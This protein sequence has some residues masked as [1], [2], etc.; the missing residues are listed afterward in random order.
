MKAIHG[1]L[2]NFGIDFLSYELDEED[3]KAVKVFPQL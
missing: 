1:L 3:I 2:E